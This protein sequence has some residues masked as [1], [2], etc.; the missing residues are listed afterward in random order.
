MER[1][2]TASIRPA[3][4]PCLAI[5]YSVKA[6]GIA[7]DLGKGD[8]TMRVSEI[9]NDNDIPVRFMNMLKKTRIAK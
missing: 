8:F 1:E 4:V 7:K 6:A 9:C 3:N 5:G 2:S